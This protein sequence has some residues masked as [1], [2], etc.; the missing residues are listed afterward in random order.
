M[1]T[2]ELVTYKGVYRKINAQSCN[3]P[4]PDGRRGILPNRM[5]IMLPIS[6]GVVS[7]LEEDNVRRRY[8]VS[9]GIFYIGNNR[10]TLL[11]DNI[12][13]VDL[14][15]IDRARAS[16]AKARQRLEHSDRDADIH[17]AQIAL[18]KAINR[19]KAKESDS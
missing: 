9:E 12:E 5:P 19:I 16:E 1:F 10:A 3:L 4:T 14:I 7:V 15:D 6:I 13:D 17:R 11:A 18:L 2:L 8:T